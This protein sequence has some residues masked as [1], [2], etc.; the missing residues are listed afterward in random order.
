[1]KRFLAF[2]ALF[3][4][5]L[6]L[7]VVMWSGLACRWMADTCERLPNVRYAMR[8]YEFGD[9]FAKRHGVDL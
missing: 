7:I 3:F 8:L 5:W 2:V 4:I 9:R 6:P 1:M